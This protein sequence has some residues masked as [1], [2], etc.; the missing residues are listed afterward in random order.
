MAA[1]D[2]FGYVY[3]LLSCRGYVERF[4]DELETPG[5]R[6]PITRDAA[7]FGDVV[8]LGRTLL[9]LHSFGQ[10]IPELGRG[11]SPG[12]AR[13]ERP[14]G[15]SLPDEFAYHPDHH[16]LGVGTGWIAPV[17]E[18]LWDYGV[19]GLRVVQ[20]WLRYRMREPTGRARTSGS[21]LD[22]IRP[23]RWTRELDDELL[24][25]LWVLERTLELEP[26][27]RELLE[28]V[29]DGATV[30][31]TELPTPAEQERQAPSLPRDAP[32]EDD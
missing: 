29:C 27:Q 9:N 30:S 2:L 3:A 8:E 1:E 32:S 25:L 14:I 10:R 20:S 12:R 24:E 6:V 15:P 26:R 5:P 19:S 7:L 18:E 23:E 28:E 13:L 21:G 17:A 11:V 16:A 22:R 31:A 4:W